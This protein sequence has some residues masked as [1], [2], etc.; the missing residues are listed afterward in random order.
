M[1]L[2]ITFPLANVVIHPRLWALVIGSVL[3]FSFQFWIS[4]VYFFL[5]R[6]IV[7][8]N[9]LLIIVLISL[10]LLLTQP[11]L[12]CQVIKLF[13]HN[14]DNFYSKWP[15]NEEDIIRDNKR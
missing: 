6:L 13:A 8:I 11:H 5:L 9:I 14:F 12:I 4:N 10:M 7:F 1:L 3:L 2:W 15:F